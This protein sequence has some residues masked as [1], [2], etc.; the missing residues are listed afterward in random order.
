MRKYWIRKT[1]E[2]KK[3]YKEGIKKV[4]KRLIVYSLPRDDVIARFGITVTKRIG[5]AVVRNRIKRVLR[6][7]IINNFKEWNGGFDTVIVAKKIIVHS[8]FQE[9][10]KELLGTLQKV[11]S[12]KSLPP[13]P[14][15]K[16]N[17][18]I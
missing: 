14:S 4:G 17:E 10:E 8:S 5:K 7:V 18:V 11:V 12:K 13:F 2:Y 15:K 6:E 16:S 1:W 9:I 3:I